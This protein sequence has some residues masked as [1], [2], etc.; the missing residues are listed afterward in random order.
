VRD[1]KRLYEQGVLDLNA[2]IKTFQKMPKVG[3]VDMDD[4]I[5]F[6]NHTDLD[7]DGGGCTS[8]RIQLTRSLKSAWFQPLSP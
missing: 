6:R 2:L 7:R 1:A 5:L 4:L 8:S 3:P